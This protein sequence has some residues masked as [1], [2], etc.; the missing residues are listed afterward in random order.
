MS[1]K[2]IFVFKNAVNALVQTTG[3]PKTEEE[4]DNQREL[5]RVTYEGT[6]LLEA[7]PDNKYIP[8]IVSEAFVK[9]RDYGNAK[10]TL[11]QGMKNLKQNDSDFQKVQIQYGQYFV[12]LGQ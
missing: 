7:N 4:A 11:A 12:K 10:E 9:S 8:L 6:I 5:D 3:D 1:D 2:E